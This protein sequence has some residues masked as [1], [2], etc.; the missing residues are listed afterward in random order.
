VLE[1][2]SPEFRERHIEAPYTGALVAVDTF[3]HKLIQLSVLVLRQLQPTHLVRQQTFVL[4]LPIEVR[5]LRNTV[6]IRRVPR[7]FDLHAA[8]GAMFCCFFQFQGS[9]S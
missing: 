6:T 7:L 1:R 5:R 2:L 9:N 4:L 8:L 3:F